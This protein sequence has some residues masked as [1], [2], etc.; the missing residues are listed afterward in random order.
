MYNTEHPI[1]YH[2]WNAISCISGAL[3]RRVYMPWGRQTIYPNMYI[4]LVGHSGLGKGESMKPAIDIFME[5]GL[6]TTADAITVAELIN[7]IQKSEDKF[8]DPLNKMTITYS[9]VQVFA[10]ELIVLLGQRDM[11]KIAHLTDW[12]DSPDVWKNSTKTAGSNH[13]SGMCVNILGATAP[14]WLPIMLPPEAMGGGFTSRVIFVVEQNKAK[15]IPQ[16]FLTNEELRLRDMLIHDLQVIAAKNF[17][18]PFEFSKEAQETYNEFYIN[19]EEEIKND[20]LPIQ[21]KTF[22]GYINRRALHLR[23]LSMSFAASRGSEGEVIKEDFQQA[24]AI[25]NNAEGK[26]PRLFGGAGRATH[27]AA[28]HAV[29][30]FML[31]RGDVAKAEIMRRFMHDIDGSNIEIIEQTLSQMNFMKVVMDD[32]KKIHYILNKNWEG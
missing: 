17:C 18:G 15:S 27:S 24:L 20:I 1:A 10:K 22:T 25:L 16:P 11:K 5:T 4:V 7:F 13:I 9:S 19:Q 2:I 3:Q 8:I 26:M 28:V 32:K 31:N 12:Y 29:M 23:K 21:D 14:D 30:N 6:A